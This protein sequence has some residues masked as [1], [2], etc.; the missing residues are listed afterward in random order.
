GS[1]RCRPSCLG[2]LTRVDLKL[3]RTF[4]VFI[5]MQGKH[6]AEIAGSP[7]RPPRSL[8]RHYPHQVQG[9][10]GKLPDSQPRGSPAFICF[11]IGPARRKSI[12]RTTG[13]KVT[14]FK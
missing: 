14:T 1:M 10:S 4:F 12:A 6:R 9:V 8:R 7:L 11:R 2:P 3:T 13:T 5:A